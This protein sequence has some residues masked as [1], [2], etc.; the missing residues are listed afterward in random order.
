M[1]DSATKL[2]ALLAE[3][4]EREAIESGRLGRA[5]QLLTERRD[6]LE[7]ER[8][9]AT[10]KVKELETMIRALLTWMS[11]RHHMRAKAEALL[12]QDTKG[13]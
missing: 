1:T 8:D 9:S 11:P 7:A 13:E 5:I 4:E 2:L 10:A 12:A 6:E 3:G